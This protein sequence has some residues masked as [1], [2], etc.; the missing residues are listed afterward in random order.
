MSCITSQRIKNMVNANTARRMLEPFGYV[1]T[2]IL[3]NK[4]SAV[5]SESVADSYDGNIS[6]VSHYSVGLNALRRGREYMKLLFD[7]KGVE[8]IKVSGRGATEGLTFAV[9][10]KAGQKPRFGVVGISDISKIEDATLREAIVKH[11][12]ELK[13]M[14]NKGKLPN[15]NN[16]L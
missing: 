7:P 5:V 16:F 6:S 14:F 13:T 11:L 9:L 3:P 2:Q 12:N 8:T 1:K 4:I 10:Q 15:V